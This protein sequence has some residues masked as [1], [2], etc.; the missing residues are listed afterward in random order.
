MRASKFI[1]TL[2][3]FFISILIIQSTYADESS[4]VWIS[5][6]WEHKIE[7]RGYTM[8]WK[9]DDDSPIGKILV[10]VDRESQLLSATQLAVTACD[11]YGRNAYGPLSELVESTSSGESR[12]IYLFACALPK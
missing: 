6:L 9:K 8:Y 3:G 10:N 11:I 2:A 1:S 7:I 4:N 12:N 5:E